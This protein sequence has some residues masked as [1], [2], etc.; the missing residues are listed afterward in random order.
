MSDHS[1]QHE[2]YTGETRR[3]YAA[4]KGSWE[5]ITH[6]ETERVRALAADSW[7]SALSGVEYPW[8]CWNVH[9]Q[10]CL[11]QQRMVRAAGWTPVVGFDPRVGAPPLVDDAILIDFNLGLNFPAMSMMFPLEFV[12]LFA[13]RLAFWH[14]DLLVREPL[15]RSLADSFKQLADGQTAATDMRTRWYRRLLGQR[16]GRY[17]ELM[18]CTMRE[19]SHAQFENGCGWWRRPTMHPNCPDEKEC[20]ARKQYTHDHGSGILIWQQRHGGQVKPI[21]A[22]PLEEGHCTRIGN[23]R[24]QPQ[25]PKDHRRDLSKDL[26]FNYDLDEVCQKL[27]LAHYLG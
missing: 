15:F 8:L 18:G 13:P 19:A 2:E 10:W 25:S 5:W 1:T 22:K 23:K 16:P 20:A 14:S 3:L 21:P 7:A 4:G 24:Y 17:W 6:E 27:G 12:F 11:V 26:S 9:D